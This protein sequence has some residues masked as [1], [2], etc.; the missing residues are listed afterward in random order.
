M[1]GTINIKLNSV[2]QHNYFITQG[3]LHRLDVSTI[4]QLSSGPFLSFESQDAM[5]TLGSHRVYIHAVV[6]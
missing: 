2:R 3:N 6:S 1:Y 5:H 4:D